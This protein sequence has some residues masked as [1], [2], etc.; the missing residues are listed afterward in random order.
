MMPLS[1]LGKLQAE[2]QDAILGLNTPASILPH[3]GNQ[4][5][6]ATEERLAI[7]FDGYRLRLCEAMSSAFDKTRAYLGDELFDQACRVYIQ[8]HPSQSRN[9]RW[10]GADFP[11]FCQVFFSDYPLVAELAGFEWYLSL[12][13]DAEDQPVL[14]IDNLG[15]IAPHAWE[16]IGFSCQASQHFLHSQWNS[17]TTWLALSEEQTPPAPQRSE[18]TV[19]WLIWR[20]ELQAHFRSVSPAEHQA[21]QSLSAG[22]SFADVC[23]GAAEHN[24]ES[25]VQIAGWLHTWLNE[26]LLSG[27]T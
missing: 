11:A 20:R 23:A 8:G 13:F 26:G 24:P 1:A 10:Y 16:S 6:L 9:L 25:T 12:A 4:S 14:S 5:G 18:D 27:I 22:K 19:I 17:V 15:L 3:I 2:F 7:Y 21:L